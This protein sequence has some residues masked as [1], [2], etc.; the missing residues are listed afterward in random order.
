MPP[1][2]FAQ[3]VIF[4]YILGFFSRGAGLCFA[5]V[6][7]STYDS[8]Q[9]YSNSH[10]RRCSGSPRF[11]LWLLICRKIPASQVCLPPLTI[12]CNL[13]PI[14]TPAAA[15]ALRA[16]RY[17][18]SFVV[19]FLLRRYEKEEDHRHC[20]CKHAPFGGLPLF[21][22]VNRNANNVKRTAVRLSFLEKVFLLMGYSKKL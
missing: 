4:Y 13:T 2:V 7:P 19:R 17:G 18:C 20:A 12:Y 3:I 11:A 5:G 21:L 9:S 10:P 16:S 14:R 15:A 6:P 1:I 22:A 8:L